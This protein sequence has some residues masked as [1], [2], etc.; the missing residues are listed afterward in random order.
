VADET[1]EVPTTSSDLDDARSFFEQPVPVGAG[2]GAPGAFPPPPP[3]PPV[4]PQLPSVMAASAPKPV[5]TAATASQFATAM[6][7]PWAPQPAP[8]TRRSG[9]GR[10][11]RGVTWL[12]LL[13]FLGGLGWAGYTYGPDLVEL[14]RDDDSVDEPSAPLAFP[15]AT[16]APSPVRTATFVVES[17]DPAAGPRVEET[18]IDFES[19]VSRTLI[20]RSD[21]ADLE[22]LTLFDDAVVRRV[23]QPVWYRL[24]RGTYPVGSEFGRLRWVRT[25]QEMIPPA[26]QSSASVVEA[27][28]S[29][30]GTQSARRLV[31]ELDPATVTV[32]EGGQNVLPP[33]AT[34]QA[35]DD[36][37]APIRVEL[38][39]DPT[40]LVRKSVL[41]AELGGETITVT[42]T[43]PDPWLPMYPTDDMVKPITA[44]TMFELGL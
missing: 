18:T 31:V 22:V 7:Q 26:V 28:E 15:V 44:T 24:P 4:A 16:A 14:A 12:I 25:L 33:G 17:N 10:G 23:D 27:S 20:E 43:S 37:T 21:A 39:V 41:P 32:P 1:T 3:A 19:R 2:V 40:G 13:A 38:W 34:L 11:R 29:V 30:V 36:A 9:R 35:R 6:E 5:N 8:P 42:S